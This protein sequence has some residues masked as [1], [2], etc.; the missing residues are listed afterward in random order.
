[1]TVIAPASAGFAVERVTRTMA[2]GLGV[3]AM[4]FFGLAVPSFLEQL[5]D[6]APWWTWGVVL[7]FP[8]S[9]LALLIC[10]LPAPLRVVRMLASL[11]AI[12]HLLAQLTLPLAMPG[13]DRPSPDPAPWILSVTTI[14]TAAGS[15]VWPRTLVWLNVVAASVLL[16]VDRILTSPVP[17]EGVAA[18]D[19]LITLLFNAIFAALGLALRRA[20][21][22]LDATAAVATHHIREEAASRGRA[23][24]RARISALVHDTVLVALLAAASPGVG[25]RDARAVALAALSGLDAADGQATDDHGISP[26]SCVWELQAIA[27]ELAPDAPFGFDPVAGPDVPLEV[28]HALFDAT[29]EVLRNSVQ[30]ARRPDRPTGRMVYVTIDE[31]AA[32]VTVIDD[33]PGFEVMRV[34]PARLGLRVSVVER[35]Q[36]V[37]GGALIASVPGTGTRVQLEWVRS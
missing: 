15:I 16:G 7:T 32:R 4:I 37:G 8:G 30:H 2:V 6:V 25:V 22:T 34:P 19:A 3:A 27:T 28:A 21:E 14:A 9:C 31:A 11:V 23:R 26:E 33:G 29:A 20:G 17:I 18:Q 36:A 24:E 35:M 1:V 5:P 13:A 10:A 12:A